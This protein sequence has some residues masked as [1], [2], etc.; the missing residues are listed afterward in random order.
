MESFQRGRDVVFQCLP[1]GVD[2]PGQDPHDFAIVDGSVWMALGG[3]DSVA[4]SSFT[5]EDDGSVVPSNSVT[6]VAVGSG[7]LGVAIGDDGLWVSNEHSG[8]ISSVVP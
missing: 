1:T 2:D 3:D 8:T 4:K 5:I 7:P 6:T